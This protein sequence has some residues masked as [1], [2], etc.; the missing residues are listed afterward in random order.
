LEIGERHGKIE[1]LPAIEPS[2]PVVQYGIEPIAIESNEKLTAQKP[3]KT[4]AQSLHFLR[5][6]QQQAIATKQAKIASLSFV[7]QPIAPWVALSKLGAADVRH[8]YYDPP[9]TVSSVS[10]SQGNTSQS[11]TFLSS[12][13]VGIGT[14]IECRSAGDSR[15]SEAQ[16]FIDF[17]QAHFCTADVIHNP[18]GTYRKALPQPKG[19]FFCTATFFNQREQTDHFDPVLIFVP[20][21]QVST[22]HRFSVLTFNCLISED[23]SAKEIV[24]A[25]Y[26]QLEQIVAWSGQGSQSSPSSNRAGSATECRFVKD[27]A[28]FEQ[29]VRSVL[30]EM[31][32]QP[33]HKVV[34]ADVADVVMPA[35]VDV[36]RSLQTLR[37]NHP[38]C[39]VFSVGNGRGQSF[40]GASPE[41]L[42]HISGGELITDALAGTAPRS[43]DKGLDSQLGQSLLSSQKEQYEHKVV[44]EFILAQLRSLD[45]SPRYSANPQLLK[46]LN[47]QHLHT[48]IT[49]ALKPPAL[50]SLT[51]HN[52][53]SHNP[54]TQPLAILAKLHPTPA[55]AGVPRQQ[56]SQLIRKYETFDRGLYTAPIGWIDTEGNSEFIVGIRSALVNGCQARLYAGAGIV[57]GSEPRKELAEI[58]L[59]LQALLNALVCV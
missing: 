37:Q 15:F 14:V 42:L 35:H 24:A 58:R 8:F 56:A 9:R 13:V 16:S 18:K 50:N 5:Q 46:L 29:T 57:S 7:V 33:I 47:L 25:T 36:V 30:I 59:K 1:G 28:G 11:S 2:M 27:V 49:A 40:I 41:R 12:S 54:K 51:S 38:D 20:Q 21:I 10:T 48:P 43:S 44:V 34:L 23:D 17:W 3:F 31:R 4:Q 52:S 53:T 45:L 39:T 6:C 26:Q 32:S 55:V 22:Q 19:R